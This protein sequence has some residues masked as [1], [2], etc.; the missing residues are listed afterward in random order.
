VGKEI[1]ENEQAHLAKV[2]NKLL[3]IK[4]N[5]EEQITALNEK[6]VDDK[7]DIRDNIRFDYADIE[8][9]METLAEIEVW[10]R[11]IDTYNIESNSLGKRL[12]TVNKLLE[13]P[14]FAKIE[15]LFEG[16][17]QP[18]SYYI[19][20]AAISEN[21]YDQMVV[22]WRSPIAEVYY[23]QENGHTS[24]TVE[25]RTIPV[26]LRLRRQF[27]INKDKLIS[28]FDTQIAIEDPMLLKSLSQTH[29]DKMQAITATIQK[30]QNAVIRYPDVPVLLVNGIAGSGKTSVLLQRIAYLFYQKRKTLRPEHVCLLTLNPVFRDYI[31]NVLPDLGETNPPTFTWHEFLKKVG[32]PFADN[33]Y[34]GTE[35]KSI[36]KIQD[37]LP[38]LIPE[39]DDFCDIMQKGKLV[40]SKSEVFSVIKRF[41]KFPMGVRLIHTVADELEEMAKN[42]LRNKDI[43]NDEDSESVAGSD[44]A[45]ENRIENDFG[46]ALS[47]I[48]R[49]NFVNVKHVAQRILGSEYV[50]A[51]EWFYTKMELTGN[52]NRNVRYVMIDEVQDYTVAQLYVFKKYFPNARFMLL[53]DEFQAI[54]KGTVSFSQIAEMAK[55]DEK[56]FVEL[57]LLTS[58]RSSP[59]ITDAFASL[60]PTEKKVMVSSVKRPGE[61]I[62]TKSCDS[63]AQY[64]KEL[65]KLI[66]EFE[67]NDGLTAVICRNGYGIEKISEALGDRAPQIIAEN[68][69]LPKKGTFIIEL[70][71]AKGLEFDNV[72][73]ADGDAETYPC[74]ELGKH[75]LY[76]AMSRATQHL[77]ILAKG[78]PAYCLADIR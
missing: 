74:D 46:G 9:T 8:T 65:E 13:S 2:Y 45:E 34:D 42:I 7:N 19:G 77:A 60:L 38:T 1:F 62:V 51:A 56:E 37:I 32:V 47:C 16:E 36:Q 27:E 52:C 30:E 43:D 54:R 75:C 44:H 40:M 24:Y 58:Y 39:V 49:C 67:K 73:L 63:D 33:E 18:E 68:D 11:Y 64:Y 70:A 78:R 76:T 50:T 6:A 15:L 57:S 14:Y 28:F 53:G 59:E 29:S 72:I 3:D 31:D 22:D 61:A 41:S 5:I 35:A 71:L 4:K 20:R 69:G 17:S 48:R 12:E 23:N 25:D 66:D 26:D 10:N 55:E 21:K